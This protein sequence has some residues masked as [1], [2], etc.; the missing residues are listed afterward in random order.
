MT[1]KQSSIYSMLRRVLLFMKKF[2]NLFTE[3]E[4]LND[5][6]TNLE[7]KLDEID[8]FREQQAKDI[9]GL[10]KQKNVLRKT[11]LQKAVE[12]S[13][14][15]LVYA[16]IVGNEILANEMYYTESDFNRMS[17]NELDTALGVVYKTAMANLRSLAPYG[18]NTD[19]ITNL[20]AAIDAYKAAIGTPKGGTIGRKQST[21]QLAVLFDDEMATIDKIDLMMDM[22]KFSNQAMYGEY[23]DNR[24]INYFSGSLVVNGL[25]TDTETGEGLPGVKMEF[26]LDQ[27]LVIEKTTGIGGGMNIK[28]LDPGIYIVKLSKIGYVPQ[29]IQMNVPGDNLVTLTVSMTKEMPVMPMK[30]T[31]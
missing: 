12:I 25:I 28:S 4:V 5:L 27:M 9:T 19:K 21:G 10:R 16:L 15:I 7:T 22:F 3:F 30:Q 8:T 26:M 11:A 13:H 18:I 20:K 29:E 2:A 1:S 23:Q 17:D 24:K 6:T 31:P 14:A